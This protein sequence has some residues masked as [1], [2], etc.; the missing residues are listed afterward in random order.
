MYA[1]A[2]KGAI[3]S[4]RSTILFPL[5]F[6]FYTKCKAFI[7]HLVAELLEIYL[8]YQSYFLDLCIL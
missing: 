3:S 7:L 4:G 2:I 6:E 8:K 5:V 1:M